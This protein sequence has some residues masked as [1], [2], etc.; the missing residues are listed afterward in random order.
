VHLLERFTN[1]SAPLKALFEALPDEP[2]ESIERPTPPLPKG[3]LGNGEVKRAIV[4]ALA[5]VD[6]PMRGADI[7]Q[8]VERLLG[9]Q[10]SK[11]SVSCCLAA[12]VRGKEPRFERVAYGCYR[13]LPLT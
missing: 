5:A 12:G 7:H 4:K 9:R 3:R 10:V 11:N 6:E 2:L 8:A 1:P 13:L